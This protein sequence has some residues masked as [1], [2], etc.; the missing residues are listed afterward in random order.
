MTAYPQTPGEW[1]AAIE[2][3][4]GLKS[5]EARSAFACGKFPYDRLEGWIRTVFGQGFGPN[6]VPALVRNQRGLVR[7]AY[8]GGAEPYWPGSDKMG[9]AL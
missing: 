5:E 2:Q 4:L 3:G 1:A 6:F 7:W 8:G 9:E